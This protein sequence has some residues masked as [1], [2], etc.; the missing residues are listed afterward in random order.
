MPGGPV[1]VKESW[2]LVSLVLV[3]LP[4]TVIRDPASWPV[5][6]AALATG[7]CPVVGAVA[8]PGDGAGAAALLSSVPVQVFAGEGVGDPGHGLSWPN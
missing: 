6:A 7:V 4:V 3:L 1:Q 8:V 2:A 5:S